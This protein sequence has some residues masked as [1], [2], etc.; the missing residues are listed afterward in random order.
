MDEGTQNYSLDDK[1]ARTNP[2]VLID[3]TKSAGHGLKTTHTDLS[4]NEESRS[5]EISKKIKLEDISN[6][7][8]DTRSDFISTDFPEDEPII[9]TDKS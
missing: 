8:Y 7:M 6:L 9:V 4:T 1:F 5:D 2:S 3:K